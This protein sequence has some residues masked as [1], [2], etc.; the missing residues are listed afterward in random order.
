MSP[1]R[2]PHLSAPLSAAGEHINTTEDRAALHVATRAPRDKV[3]SAPRSASS[4]NSTRE[5]NI[6][7]VPHNIPQSSQSALRPA[8]LCQKIIVE[9][10]D[11]VPDVHAVLDKIKAFTEKVRSGE[12][13]GATGKPLKDVVAIG[14]GGSFLGPLFV[15]TSLKTNQDCMHSAVGRHLR[16]LAN[17]DPVRPAPR[18]EIP[19]KTV[20]PTLRA[21]CPRPAVPHC[22]LPQPLRNMVN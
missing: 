14:I 7:P 5:A 6:P 13:V 17:V 4:R 19:L 16:F 1:I 21:V 3:L 12:W 10:R 15:H 11:V 9:G 18:T 2:R 20:I 22:G 8:P